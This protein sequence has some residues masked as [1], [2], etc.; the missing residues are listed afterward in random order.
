VAPKVTPPPAIAAPPD[1]GPPWTWLLSVLLGGV[2]L[3][4]GARAARRALTLRHLARPFWPEPVDQRISN[5]WQRMLIGLRD[6]GIQARANEQPQA[7]ARRV[8]INGMKACATI[9]E[10]VRHGVRVDASDLASMDA[11]ASA[12]YRTSREQAGLA[13]RVAG[14]FRWPLA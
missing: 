10:R 11:A 14:S 3:H 12:V 9:L 8:G 4:L 6:A 2:A 13:G 1:A 5:Q 7:F